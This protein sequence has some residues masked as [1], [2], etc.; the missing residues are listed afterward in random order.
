MI[1]PNLLNKSASQYQISAE[2]PFTVDR[3]TIILYRN[4]EKQNNNKN[5]YFHVVVSRRDVRP[6]LYLKI[7]QRDLNLHFA[8]CY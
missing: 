1:N 3:E 4:D 2:L 7:Y 8:Q 6:Y 5:L